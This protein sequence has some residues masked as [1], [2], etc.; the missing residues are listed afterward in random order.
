MTQTAE[1]VTATSPH[2][3][4]RVL[5]AD[6]RGRDADFVKLAPGAA[7]SG[8]VSV[9]VYGGSDPLLRAVYEAAQ[10]YAA[11]GPKRDIYFLQA[12]DNDD[13]P[14][15]VNVTVWSNG[16]KHRTII[17]E[18]AE[19]AVTRDFAELTTRARQHMDG[20]HN[21][22]LAQLSEGPRVIAALE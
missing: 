8:R 2:E 16:R 14:N 1:A 22:H 21:E 9:I 20:A 11:S 19:S 4:G 3:A 5:Y 10:A 17:V 12:S 18:N 6:I 13:D 15:T 7:S